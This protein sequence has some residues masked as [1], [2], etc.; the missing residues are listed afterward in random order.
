MVFHLPDFG[1]LCAP[2]KGNASNK[3]SEKWKTNLINNNE[4]AESVRAENKRGWKFVVWKT[5]TR[6]KMSF[7]RKMAVLKK[8]HW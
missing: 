5:H 8:T 1:S 4:Y 7:D 6:T 3:K 2:S